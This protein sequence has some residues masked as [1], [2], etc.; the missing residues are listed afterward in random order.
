VSGIVVGV[1]LMAVLLALLQGM[2]TQFTEMLRGIGGADI[3]VY[4][5]TTPTRERE[6]MIQPYDT[7]NQS[8]ADIIKNN[9][10]EVYA[11][12]PT[13]AV[14]GVVNATQCT[15]TGIEP[16]TYDA[17]TSGL[18]IMSGTSL[19]EGEG[20][21][22]VLGKVL[23]DSLG[24]SIGDA[25]SIGTATTETKS[26]I[27]VG[28]FET[29]MSFLDRSCYIHLDVAQNLTEKHG[30]I[31]TI[32][33]KCTNPDVVD[34]VANTIQIRIEG[35]RVVTQKILVQQVSQITNTLGVFVGAIGIVAL[36]AGSF[37]VMNT[38][39]M[40]VFERTRE[41]G[42]LKAIGAR[43]STIL[44]MFLAEASLI[45]ILSGVVGCIIGVIAA[46]AFPIFSRVA[47]RGSADIPLLVTPVVTPT[48]L[49]IA[50]ALGLTVSILAGLYP[51]WRAARMKTVEALRHA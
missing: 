27:V 12:S 43:N 46:F 2:N 47:T 30:L 50:L 38:M 26:F 42:V 39:A 36:I 11:V 44:K 45:G 28:I 6:F 22:V 33:V 24:A 51:A 18:N 13:L 31:S 5:A 20:N 7:I 15:I 37:G 40:S 21:A 32:L 41:I 3:T 4:N 16:D 49:G 35:V 34:Y 48:I 17:V 1:A 25:V 23:S 10:S 19:P 9:I 14:N 29:G 8:Y